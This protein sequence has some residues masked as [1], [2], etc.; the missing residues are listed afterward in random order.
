MTHG[1]R[2]VKER[3][4]CLKGDKL[5]MSTNTP[6]MSIFDITFLRRSGQYIRQVMDM[7]CHFIAHP[8]QH[9]HHDVQANLSLLACLFSSHATQLPTRNQSLHQF[10]PCLC[11]TDEV[12]DTRSNTSRVHPGR[13]QLLRRHPHQRIRILQLCTW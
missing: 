4:A 9:Q 8:Q 11:S 2:A 5:R 6:P 13:Q 1:E 12:V 10:Q 7:I 3:A